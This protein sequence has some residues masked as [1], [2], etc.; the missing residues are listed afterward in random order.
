MH[1]GGG[2][3]STSTPPDKT[4]G[5]RKWKKKNNYANEL[6]PTRAGISWMKG[7]NEW[8]E[9]MRFMNKKRPEKRVELGPRW[10]SGNTL[11]SHL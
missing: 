3:Y 7:E 10:Q 11:A 8:R 6:C 5:K 4:V 9:C 2:V 1:I